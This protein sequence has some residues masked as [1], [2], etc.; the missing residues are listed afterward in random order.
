MYSRFMFRREWKGDSQIHRTIISSA[1]AQIPTRAD[2]SVGTFER[3]TNIGRFVI[4]PELIPF[5]LCRPDDKKGSAG[6][7]KKGLREKQKEAVF[8]RIKV[9]FPRRQGTHEFP[10]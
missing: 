9:F 3:K 7:V 2:G 1:K 4:D 8:I 10:I 6:P 5:P